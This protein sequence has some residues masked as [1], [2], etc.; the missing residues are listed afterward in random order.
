MGVHHDGR[1]AEAEARAAREPESALSVCRPSA[2]ERRARPQRHRS[3]I[4]ADVMRAAVA[5]P[6]A[7]IRHVIER[8]HVAGLRGHE[9]GELMPQQ[10]HA[11]VNRRD[12][13]RR[14]PEPWLQLCLREG[15]IDGTDVHRD[16]G[17]L[18]QSR[19]LGARVVRALRQRRGTHAQKQPYHRRETVHPCRRSACAK[20][21]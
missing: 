5:W 15:L 14:R 1:V 19:V 9:P 17:V 20:A 8:P 18:E 3:E 10:H 21:H 6:H 4:D 13:D 16:V 12:V 7:R 11:N 2:L